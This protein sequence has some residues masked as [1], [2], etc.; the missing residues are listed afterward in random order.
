MRIAVYPGGF[1]PLTNGHLDLVTRMT[2][3]F[4]RVVVAVVQRRD[5][6]SL[7]TAR[8]NG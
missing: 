3:L 1:D 7:F 6:G 8:T 2:H 5:K 4:D